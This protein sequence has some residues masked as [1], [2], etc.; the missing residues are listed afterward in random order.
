MTF[1]HRFRRSLLP[2]A[3]AGWVALSMST[4]PC[5]AGPADDLS[6]T[7]EA[8]ESLSRL[9]LA[10]IHREYP[11]KPGHVINDESEVQNPAALHPAFYGCFDWHSA[12]HGHW[13]L[14][15]LLEMFP[16]IAN[17]AEIRAALDQNLTADNIRGEVAYFRQANRKSFER[18]Y[19]WAWLLKLA[20]EL[21]GWDDPD[22]I[23]WSQNLE[24][25]AAEITARYI[26]FLP[27]QTYPIRRGVHENTAFGIAFALDYARATGNTALSDLLTERSLAYF[28]DDADYPAVWEPGGD[29]FFSP[30]MME[31][32]LMRRVLGAD[33]FREWFG[34]FLPEAARGGPENLMTPAVVSD[35][36]DPKL[37]HLDGLN[38]SRAWCMA[39]VAAA[40][41]PGSRSRRALEEAA[42]V[43]AADALAHITSGH[44]EGEHWLASFAVYTLSTF[45][46]LAE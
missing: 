41:P 8:A 19:G 9:A 33:E 11:N 6:L 25:L 10:C 16:D 43:N 1:L 21:H 36:S 7:P 39:G 14:V 22:G 46:E 2:S 18:T 29:D 40:L 30:A 44:Y 5:S 42:R 15:R 32:D 12:V 17:G 20:E 27:R 26:D 37:A 34:R 45:G 24:P 23:R 4:A 31:A 3:A 28:G 35:R 13:T 38:L